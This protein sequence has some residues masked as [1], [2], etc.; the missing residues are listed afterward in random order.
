[1]FKTIKFFEGLNGLRF[2]AAYLVVIHHAEQIRLKYG[3]FNLKQFTVFNNG[4]IA[5]TFF[6]VLSGFLITYLLLKEETKTGDISVRNFYIRRVLRIWPLYYLLVLIGTVLLPFILE[7]FNYNYQMPY[8]FGE[9]I[10]YFVFFMPFVVNILYG[11]HLLDPLWSIG[12]E[13]I[14]YLMWAPLTKFFKKYF[15]QLIIAIFIIKVII[16][17]FSYLGYFNDVA[18]QIIGLLKFEAM[19]IGAFG[20]YYIYYTEKPIESRWFFSNAIQFAVFSF[21]VSKFL[22]QSFLIEHIPQFTIL[23]TT[24]IFSELL[25][26]AAF[27]WIIISVSLNPKSFVKLNNKYLDYLGD[28]SYGIYM[29]HMITIFAIVLFLK[30]FLNGLPNSVS[31]ILFYIIVTFFVILISA[32]SKSIFENKFLKLKKKFERV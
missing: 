15:L 23:F 27:C 12:V 31:T 1:M 25:L 13:E 17:A 26:M 18:R 7:F 32:I 6:F 22:L 2:I 5:V 3:L 30:N 28:I 14:Y 11:T 10:G 19:A 8:T 9:T 20:A 29:Y 16:M 21:L 24:P 4:G